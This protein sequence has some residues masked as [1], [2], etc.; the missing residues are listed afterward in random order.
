[1]DLRHLWICMDKLDALV[2]LWWWTLATY[3]IHV[4]WHLHFGC[5]IYVL[6]GCW[7][8]YM[9][10]ICMYV[11]QCGKKKNKHKSDRFADG[12]A[13]RPSTKRI[14]KT[15]NFTP[16][17]GYFFGRWLTVG[18]QQKLCREPRA[19][20]LDKESWPRKISR[21]P[22]AERN[23]RQSLCRGCRGLCQE[24]QT[25]SK[26]WISSSASVHVS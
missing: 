14:S 25:L 20:V 16:V 6:C 3:V 23:S 24:F 4:G 11:C 15:V 19:R 18:S 8:W 9:S 7:M 21:G 12:P 2:D 26:A 17:N 1:M 5:D 13:M 22:F 10:Y